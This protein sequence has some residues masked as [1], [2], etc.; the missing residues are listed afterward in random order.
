MTGP[1]RSRAARLLDLFGAAILIAAVLALAG[2]E[3]GNAQ[4]QAP[5]CPEPPQSPWPEIVTYAAGYGL[6]LL[7]TIAAFALAHWH[8]ASP[9]TALWT[10]FALALAQI[11]VHFRCFLHV[12][13]RG[14]S[15]DDL[16][17]ILFS[18][19]IILL[20]VGGTLVILFN[21]RM[22]MM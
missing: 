11:V 14:P 18:S 21:L 1:K 2:G 12:T 15:R 3:R 20:M 22:R 9:S 7:L 10:V 4:V 5:A 6:A 19:V 17:L 8:W 16:S 13:L